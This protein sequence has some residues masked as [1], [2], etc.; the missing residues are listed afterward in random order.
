MSALRSFVDVLLGRHPRPA[1]EPLPLAEWTDKG[2]TWE[3]AADALLQREAEARWTAANAETDRLKRCPKCSAA[4]TVRVVCPWPVVG[5]VRPH[6]WYCAEH[7]FAAGWIVDGLEPRMPTPPAEPTGAP[8]DARVGDLAAAV[9]QPVT[10]E[11]RPDVDHRV[12]WGPDGRI[13]TA[14]ERFNTLVLDWL[15]TRPLNS[16]AP[17]SVVTVEPYGTDWAGGTLDGFYSEFSVEITYVDAGG[18]TRHR[19]CTGSE[20]ASLWFFVIG[21]ATGEAS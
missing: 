6:W 3:E 14:R 17:V 10:W 19:E 20:L 21:V 12:E 15:R 7:A 5:L 2:M 4:G 1:R 11:P 18:V 13:V 8:L 16:A 9:S